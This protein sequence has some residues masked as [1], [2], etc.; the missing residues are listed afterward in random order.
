MNPFEKLFT[1]LGAVFPLSPEIIQ[2]IS[3]RLSVCKL[4]RKDILLEAGE[5]ANHVYFINKGLLRGYY[6]DGV[7][8]IT[9]WFMKELDVM[10]SVYS[11]F[12]RKPGDVV[13]EA[14]EDCELIYFDYDTLQYIYKHFM[15]FNIN[16]R[17]LTEKYYVLSEERTMILRMATAADRYQYMLD[18]YPE[19][20]GRV[21]GIHLASY[22]GMT[23][24]TLSRIRGKKGK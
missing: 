13:I 7:D 11:F 24:E 17:I 9:A 1:V 23:E 3:S 10:I 8:K 12:T 19:L 4:K 6:E 5:I 15:E 2:F 22:L 16:G 20:I 18:N 21:Q 14:L